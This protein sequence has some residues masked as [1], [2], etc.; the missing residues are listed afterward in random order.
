M[1]ELGSLT[2]KLGAKRIDK[3]SN[4]SQ[5]IHKWYK[6]RWQKSRGGE[7]DEWSVWHSHVW[8]CQAFAPTNVDVQ[9]EKWSAD[10]MLQETKHSSAILCVLLAFMGLI[11]QVST[12]MLKSTP[13]HSKCFVPLS[14]KQLHMA[15]D[16]KTYEL[17]NPICNPIN[18]TSTNNMQLFLICCLPLFLVFHRPWLLVA[19]L[20]ETRQVNWVQLLQE[21]IFVLACVFAVSSRSTSDFPAVNAMESSLTAWKIT[22]RS[23][24]IWIL[25]R[26]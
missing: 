18:P 10:Q 21:R 12:M 13:M 22:G 24:W 7:L 19:K 1:Y 20:W 6:N 4:T 9:A 8:I 17:E 23:T 25:R 16:N 26:H 11:L 3:F 14:C 15:N 5:R 2:R